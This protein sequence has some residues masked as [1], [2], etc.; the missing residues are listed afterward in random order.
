MWEHILD[1]SVVT[2]WDFPGEVHIFTVLKGTLL[3]QSQEGKI[4]LKKKKKK[5]GVVPKKE[6]L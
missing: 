3:R 1:K 2:V 5:K 6:T 4:R